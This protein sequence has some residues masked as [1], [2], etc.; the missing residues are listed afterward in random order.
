MTDAHRND[1]LDDRLERLD[2][3]IEA[4][5]AR[6]A[7]GGHEDGPRYYESGDIH[8]ELDDQTITP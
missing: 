3:R 6:L 1:D 8:P 4:L 2:A 7:A 5:E